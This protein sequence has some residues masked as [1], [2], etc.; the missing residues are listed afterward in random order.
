MVRHVLHV[1]RVQRIESRAM[2]SRW[3]TRYIR[4]VSGPEATPHITRISKRS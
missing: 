4:L 3:R 1:A 2:N